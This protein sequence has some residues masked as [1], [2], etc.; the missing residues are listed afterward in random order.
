MRLTSF[1]DFGLRALILLAERP[2][3]DVLSS[4]A[5]ASMLDVSAHHMA[6]VM[7]ALAAA[8]FVRNTRGKQGGASLALPATAIRIGDVVRAL[9]A[10]Q[11]LVECFRADGGAC[12]LA[13]S[14]RLRRM[15][16]SAEAAFVEAL[17]AFSL[18]DCLG[19]D[20]RRLIATLQP[21]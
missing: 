21:A 11:P 2:E 6:K 5:I 20:V 19:A 16:K 18:A 7:Q 13:P 4:G 15:L 10:D 12:A 1:T 14:C 3:G 17:D 9:E 8:G